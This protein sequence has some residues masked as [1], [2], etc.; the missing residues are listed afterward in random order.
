MIQRLKNAHPAI[1]LESAYGYAQMVSKRF[2]SN[3]AFD[4]K[5]LLRAMGFERVTGTSQNAAGSLVHFGLLE[6]VDGGY[7]I[8]TSTRELF[9]LRRDSEGWASKLKLLALNPELYSYLYGVYKSELPQDIGKQLI[10]RYGDRN[11]NESNVHTVVANYLKSLAFAGYP[12]EASTHKVR[13]LS[14]KE[15][16]DRKEIEMDGQT[17]MVSK[18]YLLE[19]YQK[20]L[21]EDLQRVQEK[22]RSFG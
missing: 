10:E 21:Q 2:Q 13:V 18:K 4:R 17:V 22:L 6:R 5:S 16:T 3:V 11:V 12:V 19:A 14:S 7:I 1:N 8:S 20:T 9:S 15:A